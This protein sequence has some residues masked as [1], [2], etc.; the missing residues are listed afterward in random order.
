[1]SS[2]YVDDSDKKKAKAQQ[3]TSKN[4]RY[5][6]IGYTLHLESHEKQDG[7]C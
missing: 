4:M 7:Y 5:P 3:L 6:N 2:C 1:M